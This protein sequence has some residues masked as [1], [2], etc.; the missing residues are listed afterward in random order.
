MKIENMKNKQN[1]NVKISLIGLTYRRV[2]ETDT[3]TKYNIP[4][5]MI[6][7]CLILKVT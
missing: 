6:Y 2:I 1:L 3:T 5:N 7:I 4:S